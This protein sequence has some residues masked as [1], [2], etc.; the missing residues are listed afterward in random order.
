MSSDFLVENLSNLRKDNIKDFN[1]RL[2]KL[3]SI[4][5]DH[6]KRDSAHLHEQMRFDVAQCVFLDAEKDFYKL[7]VLSEMEDTLI[8]VKEC[9]D[10]IGMNSVSANLIIALIKNNNS[11]LSE[12]EILRTFKKIFGENTD[13]FLKET[14]EKFEKRIANSLKERS[15][16]KTDFKNESSYLREN[17][18]TEMLLPIIE[19]VI[20]DFE[21]SIKD[22]ENAE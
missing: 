15:I 17:Y 9:I 12:E 6:Q 19:K 22:I 11:I 18:K 5:K 8:S 16:S 10:E 3:M 4:L 2:E 14:F 20:K 7:I 21:K 1:L 13:L